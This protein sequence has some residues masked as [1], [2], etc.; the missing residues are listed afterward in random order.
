MDW[1]SIVQ[2]L[3]MF[4]ITVGIVTFTLKAIIRHWLDQSLETYKA[5]LKN[6][7][8][9]HEIRF[10]QLHTDRAQIIRELYRKMVDMQRSM[11][12]LMNP[13]QWVNEPTQ[14]KKMET[15]QKAANEFIHYYQKN[16]IFFK[17]EICIII[18]EVV[19]MIFD[20]WVKYTTFGDMAFLTPTMIESR[21]RKLLD[22]YGIVTDKV[23]EIAKKIEN[24]FRGL[25]GVI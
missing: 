12:S 24:E 22:A 21:S 2:N 25:L 17:E 7:T 3:G 8:I 15:A 5:D 20:A 14:D 11:R 13:M 9:E 16:K 10:A 1:S 23:S 18:D 19:K 6:A 4:T